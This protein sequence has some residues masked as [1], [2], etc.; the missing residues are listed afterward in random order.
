MVGWIGV[1]FLDIVAAFSMQK[2]MQ[3][4]AASLIHPPT[5]HEASMMPP[6]NDND[7]VMVPLPPPSPPSYSKAT[8]G[9]EGE[10]GYGAT[11]IISSFPQQLPKMSLPMATGQMPKM[12][13]PKQ[14]PKFKF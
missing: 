13:L 7:H 9:E 2:R 10:T 14:V 8:K 1:H 4:K 5:Y 6:H 11:K 12:S 3:K